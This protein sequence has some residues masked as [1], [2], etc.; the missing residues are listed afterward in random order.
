MLTS[1]R[2]KCFFFQPGLCQPSSPESHVILSCLPLVS[3]SFTS[4]LFFFK[5]SSLLTWSFSSLSD[6]HTS[7]AWLNLLFLNGF[8]LVKTPPIRDAASKEFEK[9]R[10]TPNVLDVSYLWD[11]HFCHKILTCWIQIHLQYHK[12]ICSFPTTVLISIDSDQE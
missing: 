12:A 7:D 5:P 2:P 11:I 9:N 3:F 1:H 4:L 8:N 10:S 6:S